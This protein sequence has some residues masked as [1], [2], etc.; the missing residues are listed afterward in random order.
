MMA[1]L[2]SSISKAL[3]KRVSANVVVGGGSGAISSL[4]KH[5][6]LSSSLL[7]TLAAAVSTSPASDAPSTSFPQPQGCNLQEKERG[8]RWSKWLLFLPGAITFGLGT[9]Q[10]FRREEKIKMLDYRQKRLEI[11]PVNFNDLSPSSELL[12]TLEFRRVACKGF[13]DEKR[14]IYVG[15]RSRSI[16]GVTENGYYVITP[17]MPI[18]N[19]PESVQ[20]PIL[21][22]RGWVPRIWKERSL[23][24]SQHVEPP[25]DIKSSSSQESERS[26]W[27]RFWSKKRKVIEDQIPAVTPVEVVGVVRGS[28]KPSIFVPENASSSGQWFYVDVPA[29]ARACELPENTLYV[30]DINENVSSACPYPLPKDVNTLIRSSVMPQDHLN[31]TLT[32]YSLSAAV[33]FMAFKRLRPKRSRR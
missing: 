17:L 11:E 30:E 19:N 27:W 31:Y 12:D 5:W 7:C 2:A 13:F 16:S 15:P 26:S 18:P 23:E 20:S 24:I 6:A 14:S 25:S 4:P 29:I 32:W 3:T 28:E 21:V 1:S 10:I 8:S 9:W 22:N 33:A